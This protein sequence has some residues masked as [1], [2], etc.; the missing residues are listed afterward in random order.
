MTSSSTCSMLTLRIV[1]HS[2]A[3]HSPP[4]NSSR[5]RSHV[6][7]MNAKNSSS[8][9][10]RPMF[11]R[12]LI[13]R[14][15]WGYRASRNSSRSVAVPSLMY[16]VSSRRR[17]MSSCVAETALT[18]S[19][20]SRPD[21]ATPSLRRALMIERSRETMVLSFDTSLSIL[22]SAPAPPTRNPRGPISCPSLVLSDVTVEFDDIPPA[23]AADG[24]DRPWRWFIPS[25]P[26]TRSS[27]MR[28]ASNSQ[29][30]TMLMA[31]SC[32]LFSKSTRG[33]STTA[34]LIEGRSSGRS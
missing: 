18:S 33:R 25:P 34:S 6:D 31:L 7:G 20:T 27:S 30:D 26:F 4:C 8:R 21:A 15:R 16:V 14:R 32:A 28:P 10:H 17:P 5:R 11:L 1:D 2:S 23:P 3:V 13:A 24:T 12:A 29:V 22:C 9:K 19:W